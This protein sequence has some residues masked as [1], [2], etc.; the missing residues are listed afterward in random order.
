[1]NQS[2]SFD[3]QQIY[4][5]I[6]QVLFYRVPISGD[7]TMGVSIATLTLAILIFV[8]M[9]R[10][11]RTAQTVFKRR[12]LAHVPLDGGLAYTMQRLLHYLMVALGVIF[13]LKIG[14]GVDFTG[15]AV[16]LTALSVGIGLGLKEITSDVAAGFVLLFERPIRV[17]DRVKMGGDLKI[18]GDVKAVGLRTTKILTN[19][20]LMVIV[21]NSKL[22]NENYINWSFTKAPV[23][24]HIP[25]GVAY[26]SDVE[27]VRG[28]LLA[29]VDGV[30]KL[31]DEPKPSVRLV[32]FGDSALGFELLVWTQAPENHPQIRSDLNFNIER[33][34]RAAGVVIPFP[35]RDLHLVTVPPE[36]LRS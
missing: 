12:V 33:E 31:V 28:A 16:I 5:T 20:N 32:E 1:M 8:V 23:R 15:L 11:S 29:A 30:A 21:P 35:Q 9:Y 10:L 17:G 36:L 13:A 3:P 26:G 25:V 24:L 2:I 22:T 4:E 6:L 34:L 19:D 7:G 27:V 14:L 18:E